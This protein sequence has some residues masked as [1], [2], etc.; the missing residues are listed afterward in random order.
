MIERFRQWLRT[1]LGITQVSI[2]QDEFIQHSGTFVEE[3]NQAL[4]D[5]R[6]EVARLSVN[7]YIPPSQHEPERKIIKTQTFKQFLDIVE[8]EQLQQEAREDALR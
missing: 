5:L 2:T 3:V 4:D 1:W 6:S 8:Q 7:Q